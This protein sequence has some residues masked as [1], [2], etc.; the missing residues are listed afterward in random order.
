LVIAQ[1]AGGAPRIPPS[2]ARP[3]ILPVIASVPAGAC[4]PRSVSSRAPIAR[5]MS[6]E[7]AVCALT[8]ASRCTGSALFT[9]SMMRTHSTSGLLPGPAS[10]LR[11]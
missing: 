10:V 1:F 4:V 7:P 8:Y 5:D 6:L 3:S 2:S 11:T 9:P